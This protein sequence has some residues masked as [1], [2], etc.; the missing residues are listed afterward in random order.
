VNWL[1]D[2]ALVA[3]PG[4]IDLSVSNRGYSSRFN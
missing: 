1:I 2:M 3:L 4:E